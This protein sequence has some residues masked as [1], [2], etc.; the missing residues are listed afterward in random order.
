[1]PCV[2]FLYFLLLGTDRPS[3][4]CPLHFKGRIICSYSG[5][6]S[7]IDSRPVCVQMNKLKDCFKEIFR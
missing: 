1:M 7:W 4:R 3:H 2:L 6:S 5:T